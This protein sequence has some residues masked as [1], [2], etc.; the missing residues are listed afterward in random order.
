M[1]GRGLECLPVRHWEVDTADPAC[2]W[3]VYH[4]P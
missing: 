2:E 1:H 3:G 4:E